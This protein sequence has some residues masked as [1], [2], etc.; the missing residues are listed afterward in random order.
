M[1]TL[2]PRVQ[3]EIDA[4]G[5]LGRKYS[6]DQPRVP[7]GN[8]DGGQWTSGDGS[9]T[10]QDQTDLASGDP[11]DGPSR[12]TNPEVQKILALARQLRLATGPQDY[13]KCLDL[14]YPLL[15]RPLPR[16]SDRNTFDFHKCPIGIRDVA[17]AQDEYDQYV[18]IVAQMISARATAA[19]LSKYPVDIE[20]STIG[21]KG[22]ADRARCVAEKLAGLARDRLR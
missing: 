12:N 4:L 21:L 2:R 7:A 19:A 22:N 15:E 8:P 3:A 9:G 14:C 1:P 5:A 16:W 18:A 17:E 6:P 11:N 20:I 13:Q 10:R